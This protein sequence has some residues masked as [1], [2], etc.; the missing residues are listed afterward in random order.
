MFTLW[1]QWFPHNVVLVVGP[2]RKKVGNVIID[3]KKTTPI[4][5]KKGKGKSWASVHTQ[6]W[7]QLSRVVQTYTDKKEIYVLFFSAPRPRA[8]GDNCAIWIIY[9]I[10]IFQTCF[11]TNNTLFVFLIS[12]VCTHSQGTFPA[13]PDMVLIGSCP[14]KWPSEWEKLITPHF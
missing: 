5:H 7:K 12:S 9:H 11:P 10:I 2:H 1:R 14:L 13:Q 8:P 4:V 6:L 3:Q